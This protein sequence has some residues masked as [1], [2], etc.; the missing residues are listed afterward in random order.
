MN[1]MELNLSGWESDIRTVT[2]DLDSISEQNKKLNKQIQALTKE[3]EE[4][5]ENVKIMSKVLGVS[6]DFPFPCV[7]FPYT[8]PRVEKVIYNKTATIVYFADGDKV[9]SRVG[10]GETFD[11]YTGFMACVCKKMFGG[12]TAAKKLM[13]EKDLDF[14][15][16]KKEAAALKAAEKAAAEKK[17]RDEKYARE[18]AKARMREIDFMADQIWLAEQ[19]E[20]RYQEKYGKKNAAPE[21]DAPKEDAPVV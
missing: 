18:H 16:A 17:A 13:N 15:K 14:Q 1:L 21:K 3:L 8:V 20:K 6:T 11:R 5:K 9:I 12:T 2:I 10:E 19:A 4:A 7:A